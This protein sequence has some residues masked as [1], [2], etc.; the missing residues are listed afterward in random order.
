MSTQVSSQDERTTVDRLKQSFLDHVRYT[1]GKSRYTATE[2]DYHLALANTVRDQLVEWWMQTQ[3]NYYAKDPKRVYYISMEYL[4]GRTMG[5][6]LINLGLYDLCSKAMEE[7]GLD[8]EELRQVEWDAGLGN[9]G[10]GRLA[11]CFLDSMATL[12]L[13][14]YGYGIRY[15]YGMFFQGIENGYQIE[16]ADTWLRYSNPWEIARPEVLFPVHFYG[17]VEERVD[18]KGNLKAY[19]INTEEVLAMAYDTPVP[20]YANATVNTLRLWSAKSS[21]EFDLNYFNHGDYIKAVDD[22]NFTENISRVL[23]PNDNVSQGKELRL[24]Q[25][26]FLVSAT[27]QD[28]IR[29]YKK[30][31]NNFDQFAE[32]VA[33][34]LND[35]HPALSIPELMRLLVDCEGL[36]WDRAWEITQKVFA[37]TNHT[38]LPEALEKWN[39]S[40]LST[41]LPRHIQI[42]YEINKRFLD[43]VKRRFPN[44]IDRVRRMSI[45]VEEFGQKNV[46]MA[47]LAIIGSHAINGVSEL[48]T[49][50]LKKD[51]FKDFNDFWPEKF[52]AKTNG[53]TP[54]RWLR[55]CNARLSQLITDSI[56]DGWVTDLHQVKGIEAFA[57]NSSFRSKWRE[58]KQKNKE[59]LAQY[60]ER[61]L[62]VKVNPESIFDCQVKRLHEYKRQLLN[63]FHAI[64][65]YNKIKDNP[66][67]E[68]VPRTVIFAGKAAPGYF[69][70]KMIIKLINSVGD[71]VNRDPEVGDKLK[72]LFLPNYRVSLAE[73]IM[74]GADLSEQISTAGTEASGTGNMKFALNGALTIGTLD[75]ANIEI[76]DSVGEQNIYIFG[77]TADQIAELQRTGYMAQEFYEKIPSLKRIINMIRDGYF[78]PMQPDLFKPIVDTLLPDRDRYFVFADFASFVSCQERVSKD[79][80]E[81]DLWTRKAIANVANMG[82]F[83]SDETIKGYAKEIWGIDL[84]NKSW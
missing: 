73:I 28:V 84:E 79:F 24:K 74:P 63:L 18:E 27:L 42:I 57:D 7:L 5:N 69:I 78:S 62:G 37:F 19:W 30:G 71:I 34:Q 55:K 21:R 65:L 6:S 50:L 67:A 77:N 83:S 31:H 10:L 12:E 36:E 17:R 68:V 52:S 1:L 3:E 8:L 54:R 64:H 32:K 80:L 81:R 46:R 40:R 15:E 72:V 44:D 11:A 51:V 58:A 39:D 16:L 33:V 76:K 2:R 35:T 75:G 20:G 59:H 14:A 13:P 48:H 53:I 9:G 26:Y 70:A 41:L 23:Y 47:N 82:R 49:E 56:G 4:I 45:L 25:E 22:R 61:E 66:R 43:G 38:T 29:R 60:I